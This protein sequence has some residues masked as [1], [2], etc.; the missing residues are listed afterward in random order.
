FRA[1]LHE[2]RRFIIPSTIFFIAFY[3]ALPLGIG[4]AP[5]AMDTPVAGP[6]T[7]AYA[8]GLLQFVMAWV[9]LA[10]YMRA[11]KRFDRDAQAI[12]ARV[13]TEAAS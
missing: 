11:A 4:F 3:L 6:L 1:L 13:T 5:A 10:L 12:A 8:F 7:L 2:R 9:L